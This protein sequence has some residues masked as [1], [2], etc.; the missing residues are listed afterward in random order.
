MGK[1]VLVTGGSGLVGSALQ[2]VIN[3]EP[4][5]SAYGAKEGEEWVFLRSQDADLRDFEQTKKAFEKYKPSYV[6][7]LA[8]RVGGLFANM[9]GNHTFLRENILMNDNVLQNAHDFK[10]EK[11][12]SCLSTCVFPDKVSYPLT[13]SSVHL[14]PPHPSNFGYSHAKR[15]VDVQNQAY[16][17][18]Y[19]DRFTSVIPT[20]VFGQFDNYDL[21]DAHVI[22]AL[23][24]RTYLA[25]QDNTPLTIAGT[26]KP[27]RQF[28]YSRDLAKLMIWALRSYEDIDPVILSVP[29]EQE[30]SIKDVADAIVQATGFKGE[31]V[32]D[33]SRADGQ[34]RKPA[35]NAKLVKLMKES[36]SEPF[37]FTPFQQALKE[38]VE[39][40]VEN[41]DKGA[42]VGKHPTTNGV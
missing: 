24:H 40:F 16:N 34:F 39:W 35:S 13:E 26:G 6:I 36:G 12:I 8:A 37:E 29:E 32:Y 7:H 21:R 3:T 19:G 22:P 38:S 42:R 31:V 25:K 2:H 28:I 5:G 30:I 20:N 17:A 1:V 27:L 9:A 41:Y 11:V 23:I 10:V 18:Q 33:S 15:L 4:R 14:G